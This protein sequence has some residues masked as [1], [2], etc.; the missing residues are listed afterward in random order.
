MVN[1]RFESSF[2]FVLNCVHNVAAANSFGSGITSV[3]TILS[4]NVVSLYF[5]YLYSVAAAEL[6]CAEFRSGYK[7]ASG[8]ANEKK[9]ARPEVPAFIC[10]T[11]SLFYSIFDIWN[12]STKAR[13][14]SQDITCPVGAD[15]FGIGSNRCLLWNCNVMSAVSM[16]LRG[17]GALRPN[18]SC[19]HSI[20]GKH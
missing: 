4:C 19:R 13:V 12:Y 1:H 8:S 20:S 3:N 2:A 14:Q 7:C 5:D 11:L 15:S 17:I 16:L 10:D 6:A 9:K 18:Q